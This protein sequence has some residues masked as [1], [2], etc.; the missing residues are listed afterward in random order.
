MEQESN[1]LE[2]VVM[3]RI[4]SGRVKLKSR[5]LFLAERIAFGS[6]VLLGALLAALIFSLIFFY[7]RETETLA[8][9]AFGSDGILAFLESFPFGSVIAFVVLSFVTALLLR[10][11]D[12]SY[13]RPFVFVVGFLLLFIVGTG[14][15]LAKSRA[16]DVI[17]AASY[18]ENFAGRMMRPFFGHGAGGGQMRKFGVVGRVLSV[19]E[20]EILMQTPE[21]VRKLQ[22]QHVVGRAQ[23]LVPGAFIMGVGARDGESFRVKKY[24]IV[25]EGEAK[26]MRRQIHRMK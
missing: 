12:I 3:Q 25:P 4:V 9:F 17:E 14:V 24:R 10:R 18:R 8:Y 22:F 2:S 6:A 16:M 15:V 26:M 5:Y 13:R 23:D 11:A 1:T 19:E 7:V 20:S 21:G